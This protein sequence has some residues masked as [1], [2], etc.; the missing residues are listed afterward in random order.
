MSLI[1]ILKIKKVVDLMLEFIKTDYENQTDKN[2]SFLYRV[3]GG[4]QDNGYDF[5]EQAVSI[6][7]RGEN[8]S[9]QIETRLGF[10]PNRAQIP[11]IHIRQPS[12]MKGKSDGIG[13]ISEDIY[14]NEDSTISSQGRKSYSSKYELMI[15]AGKTLEVIIITEIIEAAMLSTYESL[16]GLDGWIDLIDFETKEMIINNE[17]LAAPLF[18][19]SIG[20]NTSFEN[21]VPKLYTEDNIASI[22]FNKPELL[23]F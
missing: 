18:A 11:T 7:T 16:T 22:Q 4:N 1:P 15:T 12:K 9:R 10:D 21:L 8:N 19:T 23:E 6:F 17:G 5:Y 2:N 3:I 13:F 14:V 20:I